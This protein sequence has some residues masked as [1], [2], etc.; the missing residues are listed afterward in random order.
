MS[1]TD[2]T[3]DSLPLELIT[4]A[5]TMNPWELKNLYRS[6]D[7]R[8][9]FQQLLDEIEVENVSAIN[10]SFD[11]VY[12]EQPD[13][14]AEGRILP[15]VVMT[16]SDN[17]EQEL[18]IT[19]P[20]ATPTGEVEQYTCLYGSDNPDRLV[21]LL[22]ETYTDAQNNLLDLYGV[23]VPL[24]HEN[25]EWKI[26]QSRITDP[27]NTSIV[28]VMAMKHLPG[29]FK[30]ESD[31]ISFGKQYKNPEYKQKEMEPVTQEYA[32]QISEGE[33]RVESNAVEEATDNP[34]IEAE[35]ELSV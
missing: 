17:L 24:I 8:D 30:R 31:M 1:E 3:S 25:G 27:Q 13:M 5:S 12:Q 26:H 9:D 32:S 2:D 28:K 34:Q 35:T 4:H 21:K 7:S 20:V 15:P 23:K 29:L 22:V 11:A 19:I 16:T 33:I 18:S 10:N 14:L 6:V